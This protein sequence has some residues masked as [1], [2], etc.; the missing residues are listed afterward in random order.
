MEQHE[1]APLELSNLKKLKELQMGENPWKEPK[2]KKVTAGEGSKVKDILNIVSK[3][4][5]RG[6][7]KGGGGKKGKGK[8]GK[9]GGGGGGDSDSD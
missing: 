7:G 2:L 5:A 6:G 4:S 9:G 1:F 3:T 8:K